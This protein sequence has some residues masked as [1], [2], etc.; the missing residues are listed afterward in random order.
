MMT[1]EELTKL[2]EMISELNSPTKIKWK[3]LHE[4][5]KEPTRGTEYAGA[6]DV[7]AAEI[8]KESDG[9]Y[10]VHLG[11][12]TEI[13]NGYRMMA[14]GRSGLTKTNWYIP[15]APCIIDSDYRGG[16]QVR[17]RGVP[18]GIGTNDGYPVFWLEYDEF[19]FEVGDRVAQIYL[20]QVLP[21]VWEKVEEL[22]ETT[23]GD[24]G[25]GSTGK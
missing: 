15:N 12:S 10:I 11:L 25:F 17:F 7:Y 22:D 3:Q 2:D 5:A 24:G 20:E 19:P 23:R 6:W 13:P 21:I 8:T 18:T 14:S 9:Y 4:N 16:W 1:K